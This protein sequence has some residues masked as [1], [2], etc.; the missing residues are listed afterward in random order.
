MQLFACD[1]CHAPIFFDNYRCTNCGFALAF[2]PDLR[3]MS[4]LEALPEAND[5]MPAPTQDAAAP[6]A[7][8]DASASSDGGDGAPAQQTQE[9]AQEP[10]PPAPAAVVR[11]RALAASGRIYRMCEN[12]VVHAACS[13]AVPDEDPAP[14]CNACRLNNV[15]P[16]LNKQEQKEAWLRLE[17]AKRRLLYSLYLLKLPVESQSER[18]E[19]GLA[20]SFMASEKDGPVFTGHSDGLITINVAEADD[21]FR[22]KIR[23]QLG[24]AY[25]TV[26]GHFRH[27]IGHYYW[28]RLVK[29]SPWQKRFRELFGDERLDYQEALDR[30]YK[31][32]APKDWGERF[33]SQYAS[34][35][36]WED[37]AE[38]WAHYLHMFDTLE[39]A[40]A[41]GLRVKVSKGDDAPTVVDAEDV[42]VDDFEQMAADWVP[43][44]LALNSLNR[45]MGM[46]DLYPFVLTEK[47]LEKL[48]FV[49][50]VIRAA[51]NEATQ[52]THDTK[53]KRASQA[54]KN[55]APAAQARPAQSKARSV[56]G[57]LRGR[58]RAS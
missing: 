30:H 4:A 20:F 27:E 42:R 37:W 48:R 36:P 32:G 46:S 19:G 26:L 49:H 45:S 50:E 35:H 55:R 28:D 11:Y 18:P 2:L 6:A 23:A 9:I 53:P 34:M 16:D 15:I 10:P 29:D 41:Y 12:H 47:A 58:R 39:T 51:P 44:T 57:A 43:L 3:T 31:E 7:P 13:W 14:L 40:K 8:A 25:R 22:E 21:P 52:P 56:L 17:A 24:E 33:V 1:N 5:A 38:T 54:V